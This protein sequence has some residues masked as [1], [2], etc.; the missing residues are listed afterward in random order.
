MKSMWMI[1]FKKDF[2][3]T[4]RKILLYNLDFQRLAVHCSC[5][6]FIRSWCESNY[7]LCLKCWILT[8]FTFL[9]LKYENMNRINRSKMGKRKTNYCSDYEIWC[10]WI[11][12]VEKMFHLLLANYVTKF[13]QLMVVVYLKWH[14]MQV[15]SYIY[16]VKKLVKTK[17]Q[18]H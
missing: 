1:F 2:C 10:T 16:N 18:F 4:I 11:K 5:T 17:A 8:I 6:C 13:F 7:I 9:L 3:G 14:R 12:N 15:D